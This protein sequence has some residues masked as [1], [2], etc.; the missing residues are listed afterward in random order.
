[1]SIDRLS[2]VGS[3]ELK[4]GSFQAFIFSGCNGVQSYGVRHQLGKIE[5]REVFLYVQLVAEMSDTS[6]CRT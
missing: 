5:D 3:H 2:K 6:G 4:G 1:M